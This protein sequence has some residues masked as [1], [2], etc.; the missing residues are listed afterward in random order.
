MP[1]SGS[2]GNTLHPINISESSSVPFVVLPPL[3]HIAGNAD[4]PAA[5]LCCHSARRVSRGTPEEI[6]RR[7]RGTVFRD[8]LILLIL[9][10]VLHVA[11]Y[12]R[13]KSGQRCQS[14]RNENS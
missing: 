6:W 13:I 1:S 9:R 10:A 11:I 3:E 2:R 5:T 8:M 12:R 7:F 4:T 14:R